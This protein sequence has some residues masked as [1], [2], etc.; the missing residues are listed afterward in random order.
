MTDLSEFE[1]NTELGKVRRE[2]DRHK[3]HGVKLEAEIEQLRVRL[4]T[5]EAADDLRLNPPKWTKPAR[6]KR[7]ASILVAVLSDLHLDQVVDAAEMRGANAYNRKIA[8]GRLR[9]WAENV[10]TLGTHY[11]SD[12]RWD[13]VVVPVLGDLYPGDIHT[14]LVRSNEAHTLASV[15]FWCDQLVAALRLVADAYGKV[16]VPWI[17]G[18]HGRT[19]FKPVFSG[20]APSN[21]DWLTGRIVTRELKG[22]KRFTFDVPVSMETTFDAYATRFQCYHGETNGGGGIGGIWPPIMR[23]DA[24][25]RRRQAAVGEPYDHLLIG[26]WHQL[27]FGKGFTV[28]GSLV[29]FDEYAFGLSLTPEPPQ[30]A[31]LVVHPK[32][33]ITIRGPI[34]CVPN[35]EVW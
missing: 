2:R 13:G 23:L 12:V 25:K 15:E 29:G 11:I 28:N 14:E 31:F 21:V 27:V 24:N 3:L 7:A 35:D 4:S 20:R 30:Q 26:H 6:P 32:H 8:L 5:I 16:H 17:V 34:H 19:T 22:D 33:G 9:E 10:V 1:S 18:N